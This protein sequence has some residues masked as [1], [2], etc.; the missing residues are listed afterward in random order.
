MWRTATNLNKKGPTVAAETWVA[1]PK[2]G[3]THTPGEEQTRRHSR[4]VH[5]W[6]SLY[7]IS[8]S[9]S[10]SLASRSRYMSTSFFGCPGI[11]WPPFPTSLLPSRNTIGDDKIAVNPQTVQQSV[12]DNQTRAALW[13]PS[14][15]KL[16]F[17]LWMRNLHKIY[18]FRC[19]GKFLLLPPH[20]NG[21]M[22][23]RMGMR[24]IIC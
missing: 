16:R 11:W 7:C 5:Q 23:E 9:L 13:G 19:A 14:F 3:I 10:L 24:F 12:Y 15:C 18:C 4:R 6:G 21:R 20:P 2:I 22:A 17:D 8:S 1:G